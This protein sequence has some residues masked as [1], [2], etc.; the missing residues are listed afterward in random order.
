M[1]TT[2]LDTPTKA[3]ERTERPKRYTVVFVNDDFTPMDFVVGV[4]TRIFG[5]S[6][7]DAVRIMLEIHRK[8]RGHVGLYPFEVAETKCMQAMDA[9][10]RHELP[11][12]CE[13]HPE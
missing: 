11:F 9:A 13:P 3:E 10:R 4:L 2:D 1:S 8:G 12:R 6:V 5:L 7:E